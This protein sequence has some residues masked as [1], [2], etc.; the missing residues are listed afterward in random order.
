MFKTDKSLFTL[1][2]GTKNDA[3]GEFKEYYLEYRDFVRASVFWMVNSSSVDDIVQEAFLKAWK[4]Y[5]GF[6]RESSFKTWIYRIAMNTT[7]DYLKKN[8]VNDEAFEETTEDPHSSNLEYSDLVGKGLMTLSTNH[9]EV[10]SLFY[11]QEHT[12][13]EIAVITGLPEGTVKSRVHSAKKLFVKFLEKN[14]VTHG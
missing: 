11:Q 13:L 6:K 3:L 4:S 1:K 8:K 12:Y 10:F 2:P 14:G 5:A 9:R 7:Y